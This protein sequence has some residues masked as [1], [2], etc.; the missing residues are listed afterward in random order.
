MPKRIVLGIALCAGV[1]S[2]A[3]KK[4][5]LVDH[6]HSQIEISID[7]LTRIAIQ[8]DRIQQIFGG[9]DQLLIENDE[10]SGQA[11]LRPLGYTSK[12]RYLTFIT[13]KG[14]TQDLKLIS[15][16][17]APESYLFVE[18][19]EDSKGKPK[20]QD[21]ILKLIKKMIGNDAVN[22]IP[23]Q[24]SERRAPKSCELEP[25][26]QYLTDDHRG[27]S[28]LLKNTSKSPQ[29]FQER[30][31]YQKGDLAVCLL[32][33]HLN[34]GEETHLFIVSDYGGKS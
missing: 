26:A 14:L 8:G 20:K 1:Q 34:P 15:K 19:P 9:D 5:P 11:F 12:E 13:E 29:V 25:V 28:F 32:K 10:T 24:K 21:A 23:L 18:S 31:F 30:S 6:A 27:Y 22:R 4:L 2:Y 7:H 16:K 33:T 3:L 17:K